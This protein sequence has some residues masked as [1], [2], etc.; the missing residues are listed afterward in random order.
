MKNFILSALLVLVSVFAVNAQTTNDVRISA[1]AANVSQVTTFTGSVEIRKAINERFELD[2]TVSTVTDGDIFL[3]QNRGAVKAFLTDNVFVSGGLTVG[4]A[5]IGSQTR[6]G[7]FLDDVFL[8][9]SFQGGL[10]FNVGQVNLEP[11]VQLDTP[12]LLSENNARRL[13]VALTGKVNLS[14]KFGIIGN[15]GVRSTRFDNEFFT[16]RA[17]RFAQGGVFFNF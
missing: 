8:N 5:N 13:S 12:D 1:G 9:P 16:G 10:N 4:K 2:N 17:E 6:N 15:G 14:P 11:Y 3:L 7:S